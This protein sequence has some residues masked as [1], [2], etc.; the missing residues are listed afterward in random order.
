MEG[1]EP[2]KTKGDQ[3]ITG[4][5]DPEIRQIV[6]TEFEPVVI[7]AYTLIAERDKR[8]E[9]IGYIQSGNIDLYAATDGEYATLKGTLGRGDY[10]G[11]EYLFDEGISF[12]DEMSTEKVECL[13]IEPEK[14]KK[15]VFGHENL[16]HYFTSLIMNSLK[17]FFSRPVIYKINNESKIPFTGDR[18]LKKCMAFIDS[19]YMEHI[20]LEDVA[21]ITGL[22][23]F[24]FSRLFRQVTGHTFKD[25]LNMK[26]VEAAKQLLQYPE[27]NIS[28]ACF[29]VGF[30]DASYFARLFR[31]YEGMSPSRFRKI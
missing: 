22:S 23:R 24:H 11:V 3:P 14:F 16:K 10:F 25:Y 9:R 7:S 15:I 5:E 21:K 31:K 26:R 1:V 30:N 20:R 29:S 2:G 13:A 4:I 6:E 28:Q 17:R 12:F 8:V 27:I 18:R 19:H